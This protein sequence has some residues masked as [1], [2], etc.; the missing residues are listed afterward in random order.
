[1]EQSPTVQ[2]PFRVCPACG[3]PTPANRPFCVVCGEPA[4]RAMAEE[5][6]REHEER[7]ANTY[8]ARG[9]AAT[10]A[11][12]GANVAVY[13]LMFATSGAFGPPSESYMVALVNYGAKVNALVDQGEYWRLVTPIFIHIGP[14]HLFVNMYSLHAIGPQ[15]ERL[16]GTSRFL[17]LYLLSGVAGVVGSYYWVT[18]RGGDGPSAGA[19]GAL[20]GLLGVLLVFGLRYRHELPGIFRQAFN[21]QGL[22]P[23]LG[24]N[25]I[26]TFAIPFIDAGAHLGGLVAGGALAA[27]IPY[28]RSTEERAGF[29][30]RLLAVLSV[31]AVAASFAIAFRAP[32]RGPEA[33][34]E[35]LGAAAEP[36]VARFIEVYERRARSLQEADDALEKAADKRAVS[37]DVAARTRETAAAL[38]AQPGF[39]NRSRELLA[40]DAAL[41]DRAAD[42][43]T[44]DRSQLD[45]A[46]HEAFNRDAVQSQRDW[47]AWIRSEGGKYKLALRE[48][49]E[50]SG[51]EDGD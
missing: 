51:G 16:Y 8:F 27:I 1:M 20:F 38:R 43:L 45:G 7:F 40:R 34:A 22:V 28:F 31:V 13:M 9:T 41:L 30:W 46:A 18:Y 33:V 26:I 47:A 23:V 14:I 5:A 44:G 36:E 10:W 49:S 4:V 29:V 12:I 21:P 37:V 6:E 24:L 3:Q 17:L 42:L 2:R 35:L 11:L 32:R 25:L 15:V 48:N 19:S 50:T 39:D